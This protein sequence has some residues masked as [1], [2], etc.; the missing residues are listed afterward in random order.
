MEV[1]PTFSYPRVLE[2]EY[3]GGGGYKY[4]DYGVWVGKLAWNE[5]PGIFCQ[6]AELG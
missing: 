5:A 2:Y 3:L 1:G 4:K 6:L